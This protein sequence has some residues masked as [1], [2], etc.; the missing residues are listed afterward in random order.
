MKRF[1]GWIRNLFLPPAGSS[2]FRRVLPIVLSV[3]LVLVCIV[4][5]TAAWE[6]TNQTTFCGL[7]CHTMPPEYTT[8]QKTAHARVTCE[9][10][11]LG[12]TAIT[13]AIR[14]KIVYSWQTGSAMVLNTYEFPIIA[15]NM[16]PAR[17]V[18]ETCHLPEQF[19]N[20]TLTEIKKFAADEN[21]TLSY[22]YLILKTGGGSKREGLGSGIHW[23]IEN[24]VEYIALD[25]ERQQIPYVRVQNEDG[26]YTEYIDTESGFDAANLDKSKLQRMDCITC[27]NRTAHAIASPEDGVDQLMSQKLVSRTIPEIKKKAVEILT[28]EYTD[29]ASA[30]NA[31]ASLDAIYKDQYN[32]FYTNNQALV[33]QA[34]ESLETYYKENFFLDQEVNWQTHPDNSQH[35]NSPGCFRCHDGK[36]LTTENQAVRLECNLCHSIPVVSKGSAITTNI[37]LSRGPEPATHRN[38]N[39]ISLHRQNFDDT[40]KDC[41]TVEDPGGVSNTSFCSNSGCHANTWQYAGFDAPNLRVILSEELK[42]YVTP[43][44]EPTATPQGSTPL[45]VTFNGLVKDLFKKCTACHGTNGQAGLNLTQYTTL[46]TGSKDGPVILPG[47]P[48]N[49]VLVKIQSADQ[50]HFSQ[51][52]PDELATIIKWIKAGAPE[53]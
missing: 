36:H 2:T 15:R 46:M 27:H 4:A 30:L 20:D 34:I 39:W 52:T 33:A 12:R 23:H 22:T 13:E 3:F 45:P 5:G 47:D 25:K 35:V 21:N 53:N 16:R 48:D 37:E 1:F 38:S 31:I 24:P 19:S 8:H 43:T 17:D 41:H 29:Q 40:C 7:T 51:F 9:D 18:C 26:T 14:R 6:F 44:P 49:S 42:K 10:C 11:H 28:V 50:P 32:E